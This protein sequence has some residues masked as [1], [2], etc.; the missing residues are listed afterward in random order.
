LHIEGEPAPN[1]PP[2]TIGYTAVSD[3]FFR[4][5]GIPLRRGRSFTSQDGPLTA[6]RAVVLNDEAVRLFFGTR[7]PIGVRVQLG[8]DPHGPW[9]VVVGVA[10]NIRQDGFDAESRPIAFTSYRQEGET[11]LTIG[12]KTDGDPTHALPM[13]RS[14]IREL[15]KSLPLTGVT[16]M[17]KVAGSSLGR[18]RFSMLLLS[19]FA[20]VSLVLAVVGAYGVMAYSVSA[21]TPELGVR[22][23]LGATSRNILGLV[24][25]QGIMTSALGIGI[26]IVAALLSGRALRGLLYGIEATDFATFAGVAFVLLAASL[27]AAFIPARRA[28]RLDP[29]TALRRDG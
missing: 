26:G 14:A 1:G 29:V 5:F 23:A 25:G 8:P 3:D 17:D 9:Y 12:V 13:L 24:L 7:D 22:I 27:A 15:D 20:V 10:G 21:R 4:A 28:T 11:Y 2:P 16:T 19:V 6:P 18:R